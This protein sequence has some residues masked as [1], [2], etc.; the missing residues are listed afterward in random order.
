M[1]SSHAGSR[2][3]TLLGLVLAVDALALS[4]ARE[5][6]VRASGREGRRDR[7]QDHPAANER[8][9]LTRV[10]RG[11]MWNQFSIQEEYTGTE[12]LYIGKVRN[13][14]RVNT[15]TQLGLTL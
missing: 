7:R 9:R 1:R 15:V 2:L 5:T 12:Y 8:T 3:L 13:T 11:W 4:R 14:T 6:D 10:K